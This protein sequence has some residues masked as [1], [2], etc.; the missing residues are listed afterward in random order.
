MSSLAITTPGSSRVTPSKA[1]W[2]LT[3]RILK[4]PEAL[5]LGSSSMMKYKTLSRYTRLENESIKIA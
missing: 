1:I 4:I 5:G 3:H 2:A